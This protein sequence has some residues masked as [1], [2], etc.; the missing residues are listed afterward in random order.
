MLVGCWSGISFI[1]NPKAKQLNLRGKPVTP[2]VTTAGGQ[3]RVIDSMTYN[4]E[5]H[6]KFQNIHQLRVY[7]IDRITGANADLDLHPIV[8]RFNNVKVGDIRRPTGGVNIL[9]GY[10]YAGWHP[11][12]EQTREHLVI[13]SNIFGKCLGG[14]CP[15]L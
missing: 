2:Y 9:I 7:G 4:V 3:R 10:D 8:N 11:I 15:L 6:D 1:T 13:L 5:I 12:P 14:R